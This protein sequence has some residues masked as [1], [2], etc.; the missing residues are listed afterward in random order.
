MKVFFLSRKMS[1][2]RKP[3]TKE[4]ELAILKYIVAN[5]GYTLLRGREFWQNM[6]AA[7]VTDRTWQSMKEH[8]RKVMV[9]NLNSSYYKHIHPAELGRIRRGLDATM[10]D[11]NNQEA[12]LWMEKGGDSSDSE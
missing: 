4:E 11:S 3:Y 6:E 5:K 1:G 7:T 9:G 10:L 8:F 2:Y 12:A